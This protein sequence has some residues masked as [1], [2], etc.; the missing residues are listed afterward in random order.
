MTE[1]TAE[2]HIMRAHLSS[3]AKCSEPLLLVEGSVLHSL[4]ATA[5][6]DALLCLL[7][8]PSDFVL[9]PAVKCCAAST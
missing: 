6:A 1:Q 2:Q 9:V 3:S 4:A 8:L 5:A 7:L